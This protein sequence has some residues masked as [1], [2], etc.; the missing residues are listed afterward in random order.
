MKG[1]RLD[2]QCP[3]CGRTI[4]S[5][6]LRWLDP[7]RDLLPLLDHPHRVANRL[8]YMA[9]GLTVLSVFMVLALLLNAINQLSFAIPY[10]GLMADVAS[11]S[12]YGITIVPL[13]MVA[14]SLGLGQ[15]RHPLGWP[16][17]VFRAGL[18][19]IA[20]SNAFEVPFA[21][22]IA[23]AVALLGFRSC[24]QSIGARSRAFREAGPERQRLLEM[25]VASLMLAAG[26]LLEAWR[27]G[28]D[29]WPL[30]PGLSTVLLTI[31]SGFLLLGFLYFRQ[32]VRWIAESLR[33]PSPRLRSLLWAEDDVLL[34]GW[35]PGESD[36]QDGRATLGS[37]KGGRP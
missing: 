34:R 29:G 30:A 13:F 24:V 9:D 23:L 15:D 11:W 28:A 17:R 2:G 26:F 36:R 8:V 32:N 5:S 25:A 21:T 18:I 7:E 22:A 16:L 20:I 33:G 1:V 10:A 3:E 31:S 12:R 37:A 6:V 4:W 19:L 14:C 27:R 35:D